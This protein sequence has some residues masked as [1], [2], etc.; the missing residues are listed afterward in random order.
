[1]LAGDD[2]RDMSAL[3]QPGRRAVT[4]HTETKANQLVH[5]G[6]RVDVLGNFAKASTSNDVRAGVVLLQN[7]LVL[8]RDSGGDG[9]GPN[10]GTDLALS[11]TLQNAQM[12][13]VARGERPIVGGAAQPRGQSG[14]RRSGRGG[15]RHLPAEGQQA[16]RALGSLAPGPRGRWPMRARTLCLVLGMMLVPVVADAQPKPR[17]GE[18]SPTH[19]QTIEMTLIVGDNK[20]IP[21]TGVSS[22]SVGTPGIVDV[23]V[24][25]NGNT[26]QFVFVAAKAGST[27]VLMIMSDGTQVTYALTVY[28]QPPEKVLA[29]L[30]ELLDG[31]TVCAS[32]G[33]ARASSSR[34]AWRP[35]AMCDASR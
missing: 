8:G 22:Y 30:K 5:A 19:A 3:V 12:L 14:A 25:P 16:C 26:P 20:T 18:G 31:Y 4:I 23:K 15:L 21:A 28:A 24:T 10:E 7:V 29:E 34:A 27:T 33:W 2:R 1:V 13:G 17:P 6:D 35:T 9:R 32:A 11:L